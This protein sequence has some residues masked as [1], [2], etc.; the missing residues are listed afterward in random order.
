V[1]KPLPFPTGFAALTK[2]R[3]ASLVRGQG[4]ELSERLQSIYI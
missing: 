2:C 1:T 4:D 3:D